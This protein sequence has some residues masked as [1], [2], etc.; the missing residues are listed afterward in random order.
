MAAMFMLEDSSSFD[1]TF[2]DF[3][4]GMSLLPTG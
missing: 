2:D 1:M 4:L 3:N